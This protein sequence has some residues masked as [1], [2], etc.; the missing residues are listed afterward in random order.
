[1]T[2]QELKTIL[3]Y[4]RVDPNQEVWINVDFSGKTKETCKILSY[5]TYG[6]GITLNI[7]ASDITDNEDDK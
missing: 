4:A 2:I 6:D 7:V 5:N 1:M 3:S